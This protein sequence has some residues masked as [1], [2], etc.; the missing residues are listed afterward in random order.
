MDDLHRGLN[1]RETTGLGGKGINL[2]GPLSEIGS[3]CVVDGFHDRH[4]LLESV[5]VPI[6]RGV[7]YLF[8]SESTMSGNFPSDEVGKSYTHPV[9]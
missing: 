7:Y 4:L 5:T 1:N 8:L 9:G 6:S 3:G 2:I